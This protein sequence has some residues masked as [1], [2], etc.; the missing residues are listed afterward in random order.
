LRLIFKPLNALG[1]L[2]ADATH[3]YNK[4]DSV[5]GQ[6]AL[7]SAIWML[8]GELTVDNTNKFYALVKDMSLSDVGAVRVINPVDDR[9]NQ[10]DATGN[11]IDP[12]NYYKQSIMVVIPE[13]GT[14][15][16]L[17]LGLRGSASR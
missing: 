12:A 9:Y 14:L 10:R 11:I 4:L 2:K 6:D 16:M 17:G 13:P 5:Y 8:E 15:L 7:Q 1:D 3:S